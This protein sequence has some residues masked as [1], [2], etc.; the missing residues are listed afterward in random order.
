MERVQAGLRQ[1]E[2]MHD[3][4]RQ[5]A[6]SLLRLLAMNASSARDAIPYLTAGL[7]LML[8]AIASAL[9]AVESMSGAGLAM[10]FAW[11]AA[12]VSGLALLAGDHLVASRAPISFGAL[13]TVILGAAVGAVALGGAAPSVYALTMMEKVDVKVLDRGGH[14]SEEVPERM[15]GHHVHE[16]VA[17]D[18]EVGYIQLPAEEPVSSTVEGVLQDPFGL[19]GL[20]MPPDVLATVLRVVAGALAAAGFVAAL[21][22]RTRRAVRSLHG[23]GR[24]SGPAGT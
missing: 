14:L 4:E 23:A 10:L 2:A 11:V 16:V 15:S 21:L 1:D 12:I 24:R 7:A 20:T 13:V 3:D 8:F 22:L 5:T 19:R 9:V 17:P 18:G 6:G